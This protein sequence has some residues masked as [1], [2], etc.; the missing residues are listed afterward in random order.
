MNSE[1]DYQVSFSD[2]GYH[3]RMKVGSAFGDF[4]G[5]FPTEDEAKADAVAYIDKQ[6]AKFTLVAREV[7]KR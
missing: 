5:P 4:H 7:L 3:W 6:L 1:I 2:G